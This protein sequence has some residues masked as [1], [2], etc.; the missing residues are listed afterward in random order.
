MHQQDEGYRLVYKKVVVHD[1]E[2]IV[3]SS[4]LSLAIQRYAAQKWLIIHLDMVA[5]QDSTGKLMGRKGVVDDKLDL[6]CLSQST[7][8]PR[9]RTLLA[10]PW[11]LARYSR[12]P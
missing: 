2:M 5:V 9:G 1:K 11:N 10:S 7:T 6:V 4:F 3:Q 8:V 12:I